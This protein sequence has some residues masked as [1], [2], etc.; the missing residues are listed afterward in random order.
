METLKNIL[1]TLFL[2]TIIIAPFILLPI[3]IINFWELAIIFLSIFSLGDAII[4]GIL[5]YHD[6][7]SED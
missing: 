5:I 2:L 7:V 3:A 4:L 1:A 6:Y